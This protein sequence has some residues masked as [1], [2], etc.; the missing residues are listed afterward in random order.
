MS[1]KKQQTEPDLPDQID[2]EE[3]SQIVNDS[4]IRYAY[5]VIEDRAIPDARDGLKPSQ[6]RILYAMDQLGLS[7]SKRHMKCAKIVGETM[8]NYHP[9]G[10]S[11]LYG[12]LVGMAQPWSMRLTLVDPQ[13][14]FG[15]I[16]GDAAAA[17]RYTEA[18]LSHAGMALLEDLSPRVVP[19]KRNYDD[20]RDEPVVLPAK[21][22]NLLLNGGSGIA[23]GYATNIPPHNLKELAAVF[24]AYVKNPAIT[25]AEIIRIMPGPDF[26]TGGVLLGQEGVLDYYQNGKGAIR[27]EGIYSIETDPKG[28]ERIIITQFPEGGS[29]EKFREEVKDLIDKGKIG[30]ISDIANY[31]SNKIG[32]R[33]VIDIGRNGNSKVILNYVL[34]HTCLRVTFSVN[35]TV[36]IGGKLFDKAPIT[37]LIKAFIDHRQEVLNKKYQAEL[38]DTL[39][40]IEILEGLISVASR[41]DEAIKIIRASENPEIAS[42]SLIE[43][44][45]VKTERQA[46]AVLAITLAKLTKL[47]QNSLLDEKAKKDERVTWLNATLASQT[48]ILKI[49][50]QEQKELAEKLGNERRTKIDSAVGD[51]VVADLIDEEDVVVCITTDDCIKRVS[52]SEYKKHNR[53]GV[54]VIS[55]DTKEDLFMLHMFSAST[56]DDL[57]CFTDTGRAF[58]IK[59]FELPQASRTARGRPIINFV[60]LKDDEKV[61]AY[62][63]IKGLGKQQ[64][65]VNFIS[66]NGVIKRSSLKEYAKIHKGGII[67]TKVKENDKIVSVLT[68]KGIDDVI[69]VTHL[70]NAI[71]FSELEIRICGRQ[72]QGV[73]GIKIEE[74]DY[75]VGGICVPMK[76]DEDGDTVTAD[77]DLTMMTFTNKG[78]GKRTGVDEYLI[79]P[80]DG[81]K[82]RQQA[83]GGKGRTDINLEN[84]TGKS[85]GV[86]SLKD[87]KDIVVITKNGQMVR[88]ASDSIRSMSRGTNGNRLLKL[89]DGDEVVAS[90][91]VAQEPVEEELAI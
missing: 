91:V 21:L 58:S 59:V 33:V 75:V 52:L 20:S 41:I 79:S 9:H 89:S 83:R 46:K 74:G 32:T 53:G 67:A 24:E 28:N 68:T 38:S 43:K 23:V 44:K 71:R 48:D 27:L 1:K 36:L 54:G 25:P 70:G 50:V 13:G 63:P 15:S 73:A 16:D 40:R 19:Y 12:T 78:W 30:G 51:I 7:P 84:K 45:L 10:D 57:L 11:S 6:R 14:N 69:I 49:V 18:R 39:D 3:F 17:Q 31:S 8:G 66:R 35:A 22:P 90:S 4:Y 65:F 60:N 72:G 61:C 77:K 56:H 62:L 55:G 80:V 85:I 29:P 88:F 81:S 76:F 82:L 26:P 42:S 64:V 47:E 2:Q 5:K 86:L 37:K 87:G 34:S